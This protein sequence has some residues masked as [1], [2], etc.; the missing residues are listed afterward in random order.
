MVVGDVG[1]S[2]RITYQLNVTNV[3]DDRTI[4]ATKEDI[5]TISGVIFYR[6]AFRENPRRLAFSLRTEF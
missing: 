5:D 1:K 2:T 6:R 4:N 3:L